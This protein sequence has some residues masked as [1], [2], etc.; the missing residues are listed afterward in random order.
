[1]IVFCPTQRN[2]GGKKGARGLLGHAFAVNRE[3]KSFV[4]GLFGA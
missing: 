2:N 3:R 1:M 4:L